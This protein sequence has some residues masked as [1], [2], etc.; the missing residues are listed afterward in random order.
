MSVFQLNGI[1]KK[2]QEQFRPFL[3]NEQIF[4]LG[5]L[6]FFL[7]FISL[8]MVEVPQPKIVI[9][10]PWTYENLYC[11]GEP[12]QF[13]GQRSLVHT[14]N[15]IERHPFTLLVCQDLLCFSV[16]GCCHPCQITHSCRIMFR[17]LDWLVFTSAHY[18]IKII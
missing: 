2:E 3:T 17:Y 7:G 18:Q 6:I 14:D 12:Y 11:K 16:Y 1:F 10:L 4:F 13:S 9:H 5:G 15:Q 8:R